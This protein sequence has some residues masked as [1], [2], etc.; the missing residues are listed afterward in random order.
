MLHSPNQIVHENYTQNCSTD[1]E[2][3]PGESR[4]KHTRL[5]CPLL[6]LVDRRR[7][8]LGLGLGAMP[9]NTTVLTGPQRICRVDLDFLQ[10]QRAQALTSTQFV[11]CVASSPTFNLVD[12]IVR[13]YCST[14]WNTVITRS[15]LHLR[16]GP[17]VSASAPASSRRPMSLREEGLSAL[18]WKRHDIGVSPVLLPA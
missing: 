10:Q 8:P 15:S 6:P 2:Y 5:C 4:R 14:S 17:S 3:R 7:K 18:G 9:N 13:A 16:I 1:T 11:L 12:E